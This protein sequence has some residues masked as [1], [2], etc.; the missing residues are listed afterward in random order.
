MYPPPYYTDHDPVFM[1]GV[2]RA[3]SFAALTL[4]GDDGLLTTHLPLIYHRHEGAKGAKGA[5]YGHIARKNPQADYLEG[6]QEAMAVFS[7]PHSYISASWYDKPER[8]VPTWNYIAVHAKGPLQAIDDS[9]AP[10]LMEKLVAQYEPNNDWKISQAQDYAD[11]LMSAIVFFK[12][13]IK[14]LTGF[15]KI[16]SNKTAGERA[17]IAEK[18]TALGQ[19]D[20]AAAMAPKEYIPKRIY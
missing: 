2:M 5:L 3:H 20:M 9:Q 13:D 18:L 14:S 17:R 15:R 8:S 16:S 11:K 4:A 6:A 12:M 1:A 19:T 7:G 10:E